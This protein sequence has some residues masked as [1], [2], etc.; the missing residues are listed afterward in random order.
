M[1]MLS[2][3]KSY[4]K[5]RISNE[6]RLDG[7]KLLEYRDL[8]VEIG[9]IAKAAGSARVHLGNTDVVVGIK[10]EVGTPF[11]DAPESGVIMS[12]AEFS[13][14]ASPDFENGPPG[15]DS[16]ELSRVVD[17]G[18]RESNLIHL[19][20]LCIVPKEK[21]WMVFI[22]IHILNN[23][24]NLLDAAGIAALTALKNTKMPKYDK[25]KECAIYDESDGKLPM[26]D[27]SPVPIT[28][29]KTNGK[30]FIDPSWEEEETTD[31]KL[32]VTTTKDGN[33][34][35][36]QKSGAGA[37]T[38]DDVMKAVDISVKDGSQIRKKLK[39]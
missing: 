3:N 28:L 17:R 27:I 29:Y 33:I 34:A 13:S 26:Q 22:D 1:S 38:Q 30:L 10:L 12:G 9:S 31:C 25:E 6:K 32:T 16:I 11:S 39:I 7:R 20:K 19:D 37:I 36:M 23:S 5:N 21:V 14:I 8:S 4:V 15:I 18:I 24:G 35:A 2:Q